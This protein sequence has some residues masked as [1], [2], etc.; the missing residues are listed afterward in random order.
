V[1]LA[2]IDHIEAEFFR[3]DGVLYIIPPGIRRRLAEIGTLSRGGT[4]LQIPFMMITRD[5]FG[6]SRAAKMQMVG[7]RSIAS[8][9]QATSGFFSLRIATVI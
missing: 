8:T 6:T 4:F 1:V 5:R 2:E 7:D 9:R 3:H